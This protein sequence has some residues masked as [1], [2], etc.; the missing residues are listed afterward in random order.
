MASTLYS[1]KHPTRTSIQQ[2]QLGTHLRGKRK[3]E[4]LSNWSRKQAKKE[5][6]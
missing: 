4:E 5:E 2:T 6:K 1:Q 3:R